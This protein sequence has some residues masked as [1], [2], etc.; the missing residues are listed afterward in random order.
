MARVLVVDDDAA[1]RQLLTFAFSMEGHTVATLSDG[2]RVI[3]TLRTSSERV[4]VF[5][6]VMMPLV[7]G[8]EVCRQLEAEPA[9]LGQHV[10]V[11]MS[12]GFVPSEPLPSA[13]RATLSKPFNLER[14]LSMV[15]RM[16]AEPLALIPSCS[17]P[18]ERSLSVRP[19]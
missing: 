15:V 6:D 8:L 1:I 11:L 3:E 12:A 5:M 2:S 18:S 7:D 4:I 9:L 19:V 14:A 10:V 13:V 16:S 17:E